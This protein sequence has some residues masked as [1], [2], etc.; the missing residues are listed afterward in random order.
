MDGRYRSLQFCTYKALITT[1][2]P[3]R[4]T[5][6]SMIPWDKCALTNESGRLVLSLCDLG[7]SGV[8]S[9]RLTS[10][11][12]LHDWRT[13]RAIVRAFRTETGVVSGDGSVESTAGDARTRSFVARAEPKNRLWGITVAP[14][15]P[16][17]V[18]CG[19]HEQNC[20]RGVR[21]RDAQV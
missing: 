4:L 21:E 2:R 1:A 5:T 10:N 9:T 13:A 6:M 3:R 11:A 15:M 19:T 14:M 8:P 12:L 18:V 20:M 17:A 7:S 16:I